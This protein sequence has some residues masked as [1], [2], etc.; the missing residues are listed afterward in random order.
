[1]LEVHPDHLAGDPWLGDEVP[2]EAV[3][4]L[5]L[6]RWPPEVMLRDGR[7]GFVP[8]A[9]R[10]DLALFGRLHGIP[11]VDRADVWSWITEEFLDTEVDEAQRERSSC[12]LEANGVSREE[13]AA[14]R[15]FLRVPMLTRTALSWEWAHYGLWDVLQ[16][17]PVRLLP[18]RWVRGSEF[19]PRDASARELRR[20]AESLANRAPVTRS[21]PA[22]PVPDAPE[23]LHTLR[24]RFVSPGLGRAG[25][26]DGWEERW[27]RLQQIHDPLLEAWTAPHR[28]Y[29]G[30]RHLLAVLDAVRPFEPERA[31][32]LAAW[33][34]DAVYDPSRTDNEEESARWL[35]RVTEGLVADGVLAGHEVHL[36]AR[37]V[38]ATADPLEPLPGGA[39]GVAIG[40]FLDADLQVFA[41]LPEDYDGYVAGVRQEV[42]FVSDDSFREG[43]RHLL[44]RRAAEVGRRGWF[45]HA[46]S[47]L[48]EWLA[49][50]NL[51]RE[52]AR[53]R[54]APLD[55]K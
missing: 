38:R 42:G 16:A 26:V 41:S 32:V 34:H 13:V 1:M 25:R 15:R 33:F 28:V 46:S 39:E 55:T 4:E 14:I 44:E 49:R 36:A 52:L 23:V 18:A 51:E 37:M 17:R 5:R 40:R 27:R 53:L 7:I 47:P 19:L 35:E 31:F 6:H 29:H 2:A 43:R 12:L 30:P 21:A 3:A 22:L 9:R 54:A 8:A 45:F 48:A 11:V 10:R 20:W 50:R 24:H